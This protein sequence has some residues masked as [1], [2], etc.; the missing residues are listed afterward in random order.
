MTPLELAVRQDE[1]TIAKLLFQSNANEQIQNSPGLLAMVA[2]RAVWKLSTGLIKQ[3]IPINI[4]AL[5][6]PRFRE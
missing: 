3:Q 4:L 2:K 5:L 1:I 6:T